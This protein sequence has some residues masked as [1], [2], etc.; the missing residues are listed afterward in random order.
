MLEYFEL[1]CTYC[2]SI[3]LIAKRNSADSPSSAQPDQWQ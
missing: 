1:I 2:S 3:L